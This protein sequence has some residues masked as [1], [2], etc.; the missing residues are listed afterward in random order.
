MR[1]H[2]KDKGDMGL[3]FVIGD[4]L[5]NGFQVAT[6]LSEHLP[7]DLI[8]IS[9]E[10][11]TKRLSVKYRKIRNGILT[12]KFM[13]AWADT[14]GIHQKPVDK[15]EFDATAIYCPDT[16]ECYYIR[17]EE[18]PVSALTLRVVPPKNNQK[19]GVLLAENFKGPG[20][21]FR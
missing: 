1:H 8:V 5:S 13:S 4:C 6:L 12:F 9:P 17:N 18:A 7:F 20:R 16:G 10:M 2:T 21:I 3:G 14:H 15:T 19:T 11:E